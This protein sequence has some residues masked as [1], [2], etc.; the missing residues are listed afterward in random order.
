MKIPLAGILCEHTD[1]IVSK[2]LQASMNFSG[3]WENGK[4]R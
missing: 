1:N 3:F 4:H 2:E